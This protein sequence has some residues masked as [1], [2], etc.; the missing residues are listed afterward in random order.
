M[1][2]SDD[3]ALMR[4][5]RPKITPQAA[6]RMFMQHATGIAVTT[7]TLGLVWWQA[8]FEVWSDVM[9]PEGRK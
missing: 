5:M 9:F 2:L 7:A 1:S 3:Q 6:A 4:V 8:Y